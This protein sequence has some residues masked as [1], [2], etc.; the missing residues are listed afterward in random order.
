[1]K[2]VLDLQACQGSNQARGIGRY[3]LSLAQAFVELAAGKNDIHI[4]MSRLYPE[5]ADS[6]SRSFQ[7]FVPPKNFHLLALPGNIAAASPAQRWKVGIAEK[8]KSNYINGL[9]ADVVHL[10]SLF[11]GWGDNV[12][13]GVEG[14]L[15]KTAPVNALTH[16]DLIPLVHKQRYLQDPGFSAWYYKKLQA[17]KNTDLLLAISGYSRQEAIDLLYIPE[18]RVVNISSA[19]DGEFFSPVSISAAEEQGFRSRLGLIKPFVMYTGGIDYRKNINGLIE[20][21]AR[22]PENL[23]R[24][25]QLAIV[26]RIDPTEQQRL[27]LLAL[28]RGLVPGTVVF[29]GFV[30]D[31]DLRTLYTLAELFVFPS[32]HEGFGL[33]LLE[34]MSCGT[35]VIG[36]S[37]SSIPEVIGRE[38]ALFDPLSTEAIAAKMAEVLS[39]PHMSQSFAEYGLERAKLFSWEKSAAVMLEAFAAAHEKR[40]QSKKVWAAQNSAKRPRLAYV[41]PLPPSQTGIA[42]YSAELLP[43]LAC[44]YDIELIVAQDSV[45]DPWLTGC[46]PVRSADWFLAHAAEFDRVIYH[47]GNSDHH[48][49]MFALLERIPGIVVLHDFYLGGLLNY[50]HH[51][52][53]QR[54]SFV[55]GLYYSHGYEALLEMCE[56]GDEQAVWKFPCNRRLLDLAQGVVSHSN[57]SR[58][59]AKRW[60]DE[61]SVAQWEATWEVVPLVRAQPPK[62]GRDVARSKLGIPADAFV[63]CA[64]GM[65]GPSKLNQELLQAWLKTRLVGDESAHLLFVGGHGGDPYAQ[66][67]ISGIEQ[68][69]LQRVKVTGFVSMDDYRAYLVAA[70]AAVQL[71]TRSRG[72]TSASIL[73]CLAFGLPTLIN[74]NG[75]AAELPGE[76]LIKLPDEFNEHELIAALG[77]LSGDAGLRQQLAMQ[78]AAYVNRRHHPA[79]VGAEFHAA[80]EKIAEQS[81]MAAYRS[82]LTEIRPL[83]LAAEPPAAELMDIAEAIAEN[84]RRP[85]MRQL[86]V[87]VSELVRQD[88]KT[89]I[90]RVV[91]KTLAHILRHPPAGY[92][93][94]PVYNDGSGYRYARCFTLGFL[95]IHGGLIDDLLQVSRDDTF[96]GL[97]LDP[98]GTVA[99]HAELLDM[100]N[101]GVR[102]CFVVYDLIPVLHP[103]YFVGQ[104]DKGFVSWL[105]TV[106]TVSHQLVSISR[107]VSGQL[108]RWLAEHGPVV[109]KDIEF[110]HFHLGA[111]LLACQDEVLPVPESGRQ[112]WAEAPYVLMVGTLEPR[113]GHAQV[114][115]AFD[116]LWQQEKALNLVIV[117]KPGWLTE[118]LQHRLKVHPQC[119]RRLFWLAEADDRQLLQLYSGASV[120]LANSEAEGFGLPLIEAAQYG[121]PI[122][123]RDLEV[124][125]EVA[126][127]HASYYRADSADALAGAVAEWFE[128][129]ESARISSTGLPWL[130]WQQSAEQLLAA[131]CPDKKH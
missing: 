93:V 2:I 64:F 48:A 104:A 50:M 25:R 123:A 96:L 10:A 65:L 15:N 95:G 103:E 40:S 120:L 76:V 46:F 69:G 80:I 94:E 38:D 41:S 98:A 88:A 74:A 37:V 127:E 124:F 129:P 109:A 19:I 119:G 22:L 27:E 33:P 58:E 97:D 115:A 6:L 89:G 63:V 8:I 114:L 55:R 11:E 54:D 5:S 52:G 73:D 102:I 16:Y 100:R 116:L 83:I 1:M 18:D 101:R 67:L 85:G 113:K 75:S 9:N 84:S 125:R 24:I 26:C 35:P 28:D 14:L 31:E 13:P 91:R 44:Y 131:V 71:R 82:L 79:R 128:Q 77:H 36:S 78:G 86:L 32:L 126:G 29:T 62:V 66:A 43:E 49:H 130:T 59:L 56:Q 68:A 60:Y 17:L 53:Y 112:E 118:E 51:T 108:E 117:G 4:V 12:A 105:R 20:A 57:F 87:D 110:G 111:D 99:R 72:E 39:S 23:R 106:A 92:R 121:T 34:A 107:S 30:S 21:F 81:S 90:Q 45:S 47:F 61:R 7:A 70:D 122:L 42:D 3:S